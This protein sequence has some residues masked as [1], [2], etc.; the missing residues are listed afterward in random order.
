MRAKAKP[1][2]GQYQPKKTKTIGSWRK[3]N[4]EKIHLPIWQC[5]PENSNTYVTMYSRRFHC[6]N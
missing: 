6:V 4:K 2:R 1:T 5:V 3:E